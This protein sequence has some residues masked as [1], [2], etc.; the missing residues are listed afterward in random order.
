MVGNHEEITRMY[1]IITPSTEYTRHSVHLLPPQV[2]GLHQVTV[3]RITY[4]GFPMC[5]LEDTTRMYPY[6]PNINRVGIEIEP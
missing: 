2:P 3:L 5:L 6:M 1:G 4:P